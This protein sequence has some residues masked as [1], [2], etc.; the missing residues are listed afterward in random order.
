[1]KDEWFD[2][3]TGYLVNPP[4]FQDCKYSDFKKYYAEGSNEKASL[5]NLLEGYVAAIVAEG[6]KPDQLLIAGDFLSRNRMAAKF[7]TVMV[8]FQN[9][10]DNDFIKL[11][12]FI[13]ET[14]AKRYKTG[15]GGIEFL[16]VA[17]IPDKSQIGSQYSVAE[18]QKKH[19]LTN[20]RLKV[21]FAVI[22]FN[23]VK[24]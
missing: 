16:G 4:P 19:S 5:L 2:K 9:R 12:I 17:L 18:L 22:P 6:F 15:T 7:I 10:T 11:G 24:K 23:E 20:T 13:N 3:D 8:T 1:M 21:G 14:L